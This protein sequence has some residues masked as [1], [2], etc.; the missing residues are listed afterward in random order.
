MAWIWENN[1]WPNYHYE[2]DKVASLEKEFLIASGE[3]IGII[4]QLSE[5]DE[6]LVRVKL[7]TD[8]AHKTSE[9]EAEYLDKDSL[10]SS[11][12][13]QFGIHTD[14][15]KTTASEQGIAEL[16]IDV[17]KNSSTPLHHERLFQWHKLV[18]NGRNDLIEIGK[19]RSR[20]AAMQIISG[21]IHQPTVHYQAPSGLDVAKHMEGFMNWY[22]SEKHLPITIKAALS[23]LRFEQIHPFEDGNGRIGRALAEYSI[24]QDIG[25]PMLLS[26]SSAIAANKKQY[27]DELQHSNRSLNVTRWIEYFTDLIINAQ[28][29][30]KKLLR[31]VLKKS[32][33]LYRLENQ[34]NDR[35]KK[36]ILR[37]FEAGIDG[38]KG[39]LSSRNYQAIAKTSSATATR[40][41]A[42]LVTKKALYKTGE[43]KHSR[44][45][46][47]IDETS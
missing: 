14:L 35:Q 23:H 4:S 19:Y 43:K 9:I 20:E 46:L 21:A 13:R 25:K 44:Y 8:E 1:K 41:L 36:V 18:M 30:S 34:L 38:F 47:N 37:L 28:Q 16:M 17:Y 42:D 11:I 3:W 5:N 6:N 27:Y 22:R 31:F 24:S 29:R 40:D 39:G 2:S 33:L 7:L 45:W 26:L 10:Q 15:R 12:Q 32:D